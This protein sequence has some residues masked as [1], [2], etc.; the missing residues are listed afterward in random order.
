MALGGQVPPMPLSAP[1]PN[2]EGFAFARIGK[3]PALLARF[4]P[5]PEGLNQSSRDQSLA[6]DDDDMYAPE[7]PQAPAADVQMQD[8]FAS[9]PGISGPRSL[10]SRI[11]LGKGAP[12]AAPAGDGLPALTLPAPV[13]S[14]SSTATDISAADQQPPTHAVPGPP[15]PPV[16]SSSDA[17]QTVPE[18]PPANQA[19]A[20]LSAIRSLFSSLTAFKI[21]IP[22][23]IAQLVHTL[24]SE[25][26][27]VSTSAN[28][29]VASAQEALKC[30]QA[31][32]EAAQA[33]LASA[34][35]LEVKCREVTE[36]LERL[37]K[38]NALKK[39]AW[40]RT[41]KETARKG[42]EWVE[43][44]EKED[45][46]LLQKQQSLREQNDKLANAA[47]HFK[48]L[49]TRQPPAIKTNA[50]SD[51]STIHYP[52]HMPSPI[53][54]KVE[55]F[56]KQQLQAYQDEEQAKFLEQERDLDDLL[57]KHQEEVE[58]LASERER[59]R[60]QREE[61][62][63]RMSGQGEGG[64]ASTDKGKATSSTV[65][66]RPSSQAQQIATSASASAVG[67]Q[68][69]SNDM[70]TLANAPAVA[71]PAANDSNASQSSS[72]TAP[73]TKALTSKNDTA[74]HEASLRK[75]LKVRTSQ[76]PDRHD[77]KSMSNSP[78]SPTGASFL[79]PDSAPS[80]AQSETQVSPMTN[81]TQA[82]VAGTSLAPHPIPSSLPAKPVGAINASRAPQQVLG[83]PTP[84]PSPNAS[85]EAT[86]GTT[87]AQ[88]PSPTDSTQGKTLSKR[89]AEKMRRAS[90]QSLASDSSQMTVNHHGS[91]AGN[92]SLHPSPTL[93][94]VPFIQELSARRSSAECLKEL[95][96]VKVEPTE[97]NLPKEASESRVKPEP[98]A[99]P[100][101]PPV[102]QHAKQVPA[103]VHARR[104]SAASTSE[105]NDNPPSLP[106][107]RK[108][109]S[110]P[111]APAQ[112]Q[113]VPSASQPA[114]VVVSAQPAAPAS[115]ESAR[116]AGPLSYER[117]ADAPYSGQQYNGQQNATRG[118]PQVR[119][120]IRRQRDT[121][122][123]SGDSSYGRPSNDHYSSHRYENR[124]PSP[125]RDTDHYHR[126]DPRSRSPALTHVPRKRSFD[127]HESAA[128]T[129]SPRRARYNDEPP[130]SYSSSG[131]TIA[132]MGDHDID[133]NDR[134][135]RPP[136]RNPRSRNPSGEYRSWNTGVVD[137]AASSSGARPSLAN[138]I[139]HAD[140]PVPF[141]DRLADPP[142]T[143]P[144]LQDHDQFHHR[145]HS[146]ASDQSDKA[147]LKSRLSNHYRAR[148]VKRGGR[149][150]GRGGGG[151]GGGR[152]G[153]GPLVS[154][155]EPNSPSG[156]YDRE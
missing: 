51:S 87:M 22:D 94:T 31:S 66:Q 131:G 139:E 42:E 39:Q 69:P 63:L 61:S 47:R 34:G 105:S 18:T 12:V 137:H 155:L 95:A 73:I 145:T 117:P 20:E 21:P 143:E 48:E 79:Y 58:R 17:G 156:D 122:Q 32:L 104:P 53:R 144:M 13:A 126:R 72:S 6:N 83:M 78:I 50:Q 108:A 111:Q 40:D 115:A 120:D 5:V 23:G 55:A 19:P 147:P 123:S 142:P 109:A 62:R 10:L 133:M 14:A 134:P 98:Q 82:G 54:E 26:T 112:N 93:P 33:S 118:R 77:N 135:P 96:S 2:I 89:Q 146:P 153:K 64:S 129:R 24:T 148:G 76:G 130:F 97:V 35:S 106:P 136:M 36:A 141:M 114:P 4:D 107:R 127:E 16:A 90:Q 138:R 128:M 85:L 59:L 37:S 103:A 7:E 92:L 1:P 154:R 30:A 102:L 101:V 80:S 116:P 43:A 29:A 75:T 152:G 124:R 56:A 44:K 11:D 8:A 45:A 91:D 68:R 81:D 52:A 150:G 70:K 67:M 88:P 15:A 149:G 41:V 74:Q 113:V 86:R 25:T 60:K 3:Q 140:A 100:I 46:E 49:A 110:Q 38:E 99:S 125:R 28:R 119:N 151:R 9:N 57:R 71:S 84:L 27:L 65:L 121:W 132:T